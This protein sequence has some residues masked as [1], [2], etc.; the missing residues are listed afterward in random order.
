MKPVR[1]GLPVDEANPL[2]ELSVAETL[3]RNRKV[4]QL[5]MFESFVLICLLCWLL[6]L[7][8]IL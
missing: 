3:S 6:K 1:A 5:F 4:L 8:V 7:R 2:T